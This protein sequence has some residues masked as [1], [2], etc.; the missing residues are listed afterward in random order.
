MRTP[1]S[2]Q[3]RNPDTTDPG[4]PPQTVRLRWCAVP[5][6]P[7]RPLLNAHGCSLLLWGTAPGRAFALPGRFG[8]VLG[9][10]MGV[11]PAI[12]DG[13]FASLPG[14][15]VARFPVAAGLGVQ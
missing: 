1:T 13:I 4:A 6:R 2:A 9:A 11:V 15:G 3:Q 10:R 14:P 5:A 8:A 7:R 12:V